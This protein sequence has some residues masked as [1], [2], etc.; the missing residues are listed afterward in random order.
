V[1][2]REMCFLPCIYMPGE[3]LRNTSGMSQ[4]QKDI[5]FYQVWMLTPNLRL[6][7]A[8]YAV[9]QLQQRQELGKI[10]APD[11][12]IKHSSRGRGARVIEDDDDFIVPDDFAANENIVLTK[13]GQMSKTNDGRNDIRYR[14]DWRTI[15]KYSFS[16]DHPP[17]DLLDDIQSMRDIA[18]KVTNSVERGLE[19]DTLPMNTFADLAGLSRSSGELEEGALVL[20]DLVA[21]LRLDHQDPE[22]ASNLVLSNLTACP[23][24]QD[25]S[26]TTSQDIDLFRVHE[27]LVSYW[28]TSLPMEVPRPTRLAKFKI[29][30]QLG[31]ELSLS[32]LGISLQD[33]ASIAT[34]ATSALA[35]NA[36]ERAQSEN[37]LEM[38]TRDSS[39]A[40]FSSQSHL[41]PGAD[42]YSSLLTPSRTPS[43]YSH[44][45]SAASELKED[46]AVSRLRQYAVSIKARPDLGKST[47]LSHWPAQPGIDPA[48]YSY[49]AMQKQAAAED[50]GT[51]SEYKSRKEEARRRRRTERFLRQERARAFGSVA[52]SVSQPMVVLPSGSQ[53]EARDYTYSSQVADELP[54]TQ[55]DRGTFGSR[56]TSKEKK[57]K[58]HRKAGF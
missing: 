14:V 15:Y 13:D 58:K 44:A 27:K 43:I 32:S 24:T 49:E 56:T 52:P 41:A 4:P 21:S 20:R 18:A 22:S 57:Q 25:L 11:R 39:P 10:Q 19:E 5:E 12:R 50:G 53:P 8:M 29:I 7:T 16:I 17:T 46:P 37:P 23:R 40:I 48:T 45:T 42:M 6:L 51:E 1:S 38:I 55:P 30:R 31:V 34:S 28:I 47:L 54:M 35:D 9:Q 26:G 33:K 2:P 3:S 36:R